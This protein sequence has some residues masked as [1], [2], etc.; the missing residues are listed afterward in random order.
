M[1]T[2]D[3]LANACRMLVGLGGTYSESCAQLAQAQ[4][5]ARAA[6]AHYDQERAALAE[7]AVDDT[8]QKW[9]REHYP[10]LWLDGLRAGLI[11]FR[12]WLQ[13]HHEDV[14]REYVREKN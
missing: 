7:N 13:E 12:I 14:W 11:P 4:K 10:A 8:C 3:E 2:V 5:L 9:L 6:L 1:P